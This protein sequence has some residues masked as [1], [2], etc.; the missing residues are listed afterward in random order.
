MASTSEI[1]EREGLL[2]P[3][4]YLYREGIFWK[5]YQYSAY[6]IIQRQANLKLKKKFVKA[7]SCEVISVGF[8]DVTLGRIFD[9]PEIKT[10]EDKIIYIPC[11]ELDGQAY[12]DWFDSIPLTAQPESM[13]ANPRHTVTGT[14]EEAVIRKIKEFRIEESTP[15]A[16]MNFLASVRK[17]LVEYGNI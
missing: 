9:K 2:E 11:G 12:R 5:A 14:A 16:C 1:L 15:M 6:R 7:V 17:E 8:P 10:L 3:R 13:P 4:I